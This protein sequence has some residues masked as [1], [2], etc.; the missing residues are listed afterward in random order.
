V[1]KPASKVDERKEVVKE[2]VVR[3]TVSGG[4]PNRAV[5]TDGC[6][7][8]SKRIRLRHMKYKNVIRQAEALEYSTEGVNILLPDSE[9][10]SEYH[11]LTP[12][13][14]TPLPSRGCQHT[15]TQQ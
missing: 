3:G 12:P 11:I 4:V 10:I 1:D 15:P 6:G 8:S 9:L 2:V 7:D 5:V 13:H 14:P